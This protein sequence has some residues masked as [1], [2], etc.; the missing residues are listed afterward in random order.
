LQSES[1]D[2]NRLNCQH[3]WQLDSWHVSFRG[4]GRVSS[5]QRENK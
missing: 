5:V 2:I 3:S 1:K 4:R